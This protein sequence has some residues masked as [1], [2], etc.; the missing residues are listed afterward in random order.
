MTLINTTDQTASTIELQHLL[1]VTVTLASEQSIELSKGH[2]V[3]SYRFR[4]LEY[5][6]PKTEAVSS[7]EVVSSRF[8]A[9]EYCLPKTEDVSSPEF[10]YYKIKLI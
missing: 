1:S 2:E 8:R 9:V 5:C 7:S 10:F 6:L 3:V 4:T